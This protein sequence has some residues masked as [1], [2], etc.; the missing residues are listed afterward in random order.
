MVRGESQ[1]AFCTA[2]FE[3][4]SDCS[5]RDYRFGVLQCPGAGC[6]EV[7]ASHN[8]SNSFNFCK[9]SPPTG[10]YHRG[11]LFAFGSR[12]SEELIYPKKEGT[13]WSEVDHRVLFQFLCA[14]EPLIS[15]QQWFTVH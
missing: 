7:F 11:R 13:L 2:N 14:C 4:L 9:F 8:Q 1:G 15:I 5:V 3:I 6:C 12:G 10:M